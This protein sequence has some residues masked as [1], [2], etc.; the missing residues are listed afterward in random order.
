MTPEVATAGGRPAAGDASTAGT[1][2][3]AS[4]RRL[5]PLAWPVFVGQIAVLAFST[6]DTLMIGRTTAVDLAALAVGNATYVSIFVGFM[7]VVLAIGPIAGQAYGAGDRARAGHETK[8]AAWL[9]LALSVLGGGLML[10]PEPILALS[11]VGPDVEAEVRAYLR[12]LACALPAA[13]AITAFRG[14]HVAVSRPKAMMALQL[15]GLAAKVPLN[16]LFVFGA[17][18]PTPLGTLEVPAFGAAG[19]AIATATVVWLQALVLWLLL[20]LDPFY[21]PF[22]LVHG[23]RLG[24]PDARSLGGLVRLGLPM[25]L[26]YLIE[27]TGFTFMAIFV[28][29]L[30][31]TAV[32]GH[33]IA[34]NAVTLLFMVPLAIANA[35]AALVA[36]RIGAGDLADARR[37]GWH[38]LGFGVAVAAV[39]GS[40]VALGRGPIVGAF[41]ADAA[42]AAAALPLVA[43][44]AAFHVADAAQTVSAFVL[45]AWRIAVLPLVVYVVALWVVGL[46]GGYAVAFGHADAIAGGRLPAA[47]RGAQGFWAMA[48]VGLV[49]ASAGMAAA[50]AF[51]LA[52]R[53]RAAAVAG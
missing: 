9:G 47:W 46:G 19:C 38:G 22:G 2:F 16:A 29:R 14:F 7:G 26:G 40:A 49:V 41:T 21:V 8:Q 36:Q 30:G 28:A 34:V 18:L 52:R 6:V 10:F 33:Q 53:S 25:G 50:L 39:L 35:A 15:G 48:T 17:S 24:R 23:H 1:G 37:L 4:V 51:V 43:W 45:R 3:G 32:A 44:C 42:I 12:A 5:L 27:V 31:T 20:R 13:L 11:R